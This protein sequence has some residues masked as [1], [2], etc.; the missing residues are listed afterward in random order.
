MEKLFLLM[1]LVVSSSNNTITI[2]AHPFNTGNSITYS[3]GGG[4][5]ISGLMD[6]T[7]YFIIKLMQ[8][9]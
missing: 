1:L 3:D 7:Q 2:T 4:T 5:Q 6:G 8:I 9:L